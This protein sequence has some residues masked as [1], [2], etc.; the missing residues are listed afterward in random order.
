MKFP[1]SALLIL[2]HET[3]PHNRDESRAGAGGCIL[4]SNRSRNVQV[5]NHETWLN[6][7][8]AQCD[9]ANELDR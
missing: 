8:S 5:P 3:S 6:L 1:P 7:S 9:D 4:T 2:L